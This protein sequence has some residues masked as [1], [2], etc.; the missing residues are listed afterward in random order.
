MVTIILLQEGMAAGPYLLIAGVIVLIA[1]AL[2]I[3]IFSIL[4]KNTGTKEELTLSQKDE[5]GNYPSG[6]KAKRTVNFFLITLLLLIVYGLIKF[7]YW[8]SNIKFD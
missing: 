3:F 5:P 4:R 6:S 8:L 7:I 2:I 1:L